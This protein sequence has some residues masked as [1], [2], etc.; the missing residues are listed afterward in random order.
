MNLARTRT[1][2]I[3][4]FSTDTHHIHFRHYD[5]IDIMAT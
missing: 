3:Y 1:T 5:F 4:E 2:S